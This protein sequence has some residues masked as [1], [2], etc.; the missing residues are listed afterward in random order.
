MARAGGNPLAERRRERVTVPTFKE[1]AQTVHAAH[2]ATF[3]NAK[4]KAQ[5]LASLAADVFPVFGER[6][7]NAIESSDVLKALSPSRR[8]SDDSEGSGSRLPA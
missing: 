5:W 2:A 6:P 7:V 8:A 4:H 3:R 1:A